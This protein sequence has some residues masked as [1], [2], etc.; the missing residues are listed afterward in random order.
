MICVRQKEETIITKPEDNLSDNHFAEFYFI[1]FIYLFIY[2]SM[3]AW[4]L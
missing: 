3:E 1:S 4:C 2:F